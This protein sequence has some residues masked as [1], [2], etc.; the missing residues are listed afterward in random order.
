M[1][2]TNRRQF[3]AAAASLATSAFDANAAPAARKPFRLG[4]IISPDTHPEA[5]FAKVKAL[6]L[7]TCFVSTDRYDPAWA[8]QVKNLLE[9]YS[10]EPTAVETL[11]GGEMVWDFMRG[12]ATIGLVPRKTRQMRIDA[13]KRGS[14]FAKLVGSPFVQTHCG[15]IPEDPNDPLYAELVAAVRDVASHCR[16]NGQ[17]FLFETGQETPTALMRT[18]A[19]VGLDNLGVGLDTANLILYGK[20]NPADATE[21]F[22]KTVLTIHAKD[23]R[24]PT[25]PHLLGEEVPIGQG[26]VDFAR[27]FRT[28][29]ANGYQ[30][31]VTIER[32]ISGPQQVEDVRK[33][34]EYLNRTISAM[35][36]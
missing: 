8:T 2:A 1:P 28:L 18:I 32:E 22:G 4:I 17:R 10:V 7:S 25:N 33:G 36:A 30:G 6:G 29:K 35:G 9:K 5:E 11:G 23:G 31:A 24:Y 19:D 26:K 27:V 14:D 20:A 3:L 12:P 21:I 34:I 13:L 16:G 15:F